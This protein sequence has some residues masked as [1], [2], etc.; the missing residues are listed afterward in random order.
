MH[1]FVVA[2]VSATITVDSPTPDPV[3][4]ND[5]LSLR[6][7]WVVESTNIAGDSHGKGAVFEF[8]DNGV[9]IT[10]GKEVLEGQIELRAANHPKE[11]DFAYEDRDRNR[12][13]MRF[14]YDLDRDRLT[15][16]YDGDDRPPPKEL[17]RGFIRYRL[18]KRRE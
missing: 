7:A 1:L 10:S 14:I 11:M 12:H 8:S 15:L 13:R 2:I 3:R 17:D 9:T 18:R 6:G 5:H 16:S 4:A